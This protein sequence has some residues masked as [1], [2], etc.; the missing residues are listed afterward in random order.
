MADGYDRIGDAYLRLVQ[1]SG[2]DVRGRYLQMLA[3]LIEPGGRIVELGCGAGTPMTAALAQRFDV[4][5]VDISRNQLARASVNAPSARLVRSD[6]SRLPFT[7]A[8]ADAVAAFYSI[9][10]VPRSEHLQ[11]LGEVRRV[12][13]HHGVAVLTMGARDNPD[14]YEADWLGAPM[15][16]SHFDGDT[17]A[18][19]LRT[20]RFDLLHARDET[21]DEFGVPV[22]FRWIVARKRGG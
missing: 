17:T 6:I 2:M 15:F 14:G 7:D 11:L 5:G 20:A 22:T 8:C 1:H 9:T 12:L 18:R 21:E 4:V 19:L 16:F 10:H 3:D 13:R